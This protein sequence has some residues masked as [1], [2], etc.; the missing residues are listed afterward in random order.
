MAKKYTQKEVDE[1][2]RRLSQSL[3]SK[4][5]ERIA[6]TVK[7]F[8]RVSDRLGSNSY[9][10]PYN[11]FGFYTISW[12]LINKKPKDVSELTAFEMIEDIHKFLGVNYDESLKAPT[13]TK[14]KKA[15]KPAAKK[16]SKTKK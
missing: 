6:E 12:D 3:T 11:D 4:F 14:A 5:D 16:K 1:K 8:S 9:R 13:L 15:T 10:V 2:L 7:Q